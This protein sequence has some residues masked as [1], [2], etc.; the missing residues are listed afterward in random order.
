MRQ[1]AP[2]ES[3]YLDKFEV[4]EQVADG[5]H[6][7]PHTD[8]L[9]AL[10]RAI[11]LE[12][13]GPL[14][15]RIRNVDARADDYHKSLLN[16][17]ALF[18]CRYVNESRADQLRLFPVITPELVTKVG[19]VQRVSQ[20]TPRG[21]HHQFRFF[22]GQDFVPDIYVCGK[23]LVYTEHVLRRFTER[24]PTWAGAD[25]MELLAIFFFNPL[26]VTTVGQSPAFL[27]PYNHSL[28]A[29]TFE[30]SAEEIVVTTCLTNREIHR[31]EFSA[32]PRVYN[33]HYGTAFT[34]PVIRNWL[35]ESWA[36]DLDELWQKQAPLAAPVEKPKRL[37]SWAKTTLI[38]EQHAPKMCR[39]PGCRMQ[40]MDQL[41][42]L[43]VRF[44]PPP[45]PVPRPATLEELNATIVAEPANAR[46]YYDRSLWYKA[47][48]DEPRALADLDKAIELDPAGPD[49]FNER[50][51]IYFKR[52]DITAALRDVNEA[53]RLNPR[54]STAYDSRAWIEFACGNLAAAETDCRR[55][56]EFV[57]LIPNAHYTRGLLYFMAK[58]YARAIAEWIQAVALAPVWTDDLAPW[59]EKAVQAATGVTSNNQPSPVGHIV[60]AQ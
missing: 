43:S 48:Q 11:N 29:F 39:V 25:L 40:F 54:D 17:A 4:V 50:G 45:K 1:H 47:Q 36:K 56:L 42:G 6:R 23:R 31:L 16:L 34:P 46:R 35:P 58:D 9:A 49:V 13:Y 20:S 14:P 3:I 41:P 51:W 33:S 5:T 22:T 10:S 8:Q 12:F 57:R 2:F 15:N 32:P 19:I 55:S 30:E 26:I 24:V 18:F 7:Y 44:L 53:L 37:A 28:L 38:I 52:G 21:R 59:L 27:F 60:E